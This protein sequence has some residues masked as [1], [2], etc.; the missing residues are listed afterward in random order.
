MKW[1]TFGYAMADDS[2]EKPS[3]SHDIASKWKFILI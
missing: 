3:A 2:E 1:L